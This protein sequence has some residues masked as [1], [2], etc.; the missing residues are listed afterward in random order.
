[1]RKV[2]D[3]VRERSQALAD[4]QPERVDLDAPDQFWFK[5][6]LHILEM[7]E[8]VPAE[9]QIRLRGEDLMADP[10][11]YLRQIAEWLGLRTDADA[12]DAMMHPENSPFAKYGPSNAR[13][14]NDPNFMESP[15]LRHY[16][17]K[18]SP[19]T[20][21]ASDGTT[22]DLSDSIRA[23]AMIFGY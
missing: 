16:K 14:G 2:R 8:T 15:A 21:T 4:R 1:M 22:H 9:Q 20:W 18:A 7:L 10:A 12:V 5:P 13:Y 23:Y 17:P 3:S 6:H 19:L 11:N